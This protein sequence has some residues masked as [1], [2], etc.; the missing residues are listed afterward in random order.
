MKDIEC[1]EK[2]S[3]SADWS[4]CVLGM[5]YPTQNFDGKHLQNPDHKSKI[6]TAP[7]GPAKQQR[8]IKTNRLK[9]MQENKIQIPNPQMGK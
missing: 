5:Q 1:L 8:E 3:R 4:R 7:F 6:Q 2:N 9:P